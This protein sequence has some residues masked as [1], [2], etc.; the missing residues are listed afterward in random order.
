MGKRSAPIH[1]AG[2]FSAIFSTI[3]T[4]LSFLIPPI[5]NPK[6]TLSTLRADVRQI[7]GLTRKS[8]HQELIEF[9][10]YVDRLVQQLVLALE[11]D[12][13]AGQANVVKNLEELQKTLLSIL[14]RISR[15]HGAGGQMRQQLHDALSAFQFVAVLGLLAK[16]ANPRT[17]G[18]VADPPEQ[19]QSQT[20]EPSR[21]QP[22]Q[23]RQ[24]AKPNQDDRF[25]HPHPTTQPYTPRT[26]PQPIAPTATPSSPETGEI[27]IA[28]MNVERCR[29]SLRHSHS[30][31]RIMELASAL[32]QL[33]V[34]LEQ[35]G[36][37]CE[38]LEA[39]QESAERYRS[40]AE[41]PR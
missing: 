27:S 29:R 23:S 37:T 39:S 13:V 2:V 33:S 3:T 25:L 6:L 11:N 7:V 4:L 28:F 20:P 18:T 34:L 32:G 30:P 19:Y 8:Q 10:E 22:R 35:A 1:S 40:L 41:Q 15:I 38:A 24:P 21:P 12:Q 26:K 9:G 17:G 16:D 36:R 5:V 31:N 14:Q